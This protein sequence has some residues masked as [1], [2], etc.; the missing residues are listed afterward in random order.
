[1]LSFLII[2]ADFKQIIVFDQYVIV[3]KGIFLGN[4]YAC[5]GMFK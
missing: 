1:M 4:G 2:K 5:D 3:K